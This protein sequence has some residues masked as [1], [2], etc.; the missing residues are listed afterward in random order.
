MCAVVRIQ[1]K[2]SRQPEV[3][4]EFTT[5]IASIVTVSRFELA[6]VQPRACACS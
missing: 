1:L 4:L 2:V 6:C 3:F 5:I